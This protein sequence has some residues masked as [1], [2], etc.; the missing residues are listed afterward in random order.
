[1]NSEAAEIAK[2]T[3]IE[4]GLGFT[5]EQIDAAHEYQKK[6]FGNHFETSKQQT[7]WLTNYLLDAG[8]VQASLPPAPAAPL[9]TYTLKELQG[10]IPVGLD[11]KKKETYLSDKDFMAMFGKNKEEFA[12]LPKWKRDA[13]KKKYN[14]F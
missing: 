13:A 14:L 2:Q 8:K 10:E 3:V 6:N 12:A 4:L 9:S 5:A 7:E 11:P 1:M